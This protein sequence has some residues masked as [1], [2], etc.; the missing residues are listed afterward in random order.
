M[1]K[2][3]FVIDVV[4]RYRNWKLINKLIIVISIYFPRPHLL[5]SH[6]SKNEEF[7]KLRAI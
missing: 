6:L 7:D 3:T 5:V 1:S 4:T 2:F